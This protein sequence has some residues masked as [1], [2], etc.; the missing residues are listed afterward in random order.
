LIR[1][2]FSII[3]ALA[4]SL[5]CSA[6]ASAQTFANIPALSFAKA[7]GG[8]NPLPQ[9]LT[10]NSSG[11]TAFAYS[12]AAT[13][14]T[15]GA[16]LQVAPSGGACC[17]TP[18]TVTVSVAP[19]V[20]LA[21]GTYTGKIVLT[22]YSDASVTL[23]IPVTLT[24]SAATASFFDD[25]PGQVSFSLVPTGN[26][27]PSQFLQVRNGGTGALNWSLSSTTA[28]GGKWL[29]LSATSGAAPSLV[30]MAINPA[31]L[32]GAGKVAGAYIGQL[33]LAATGNSVT[34]PIS[35][36][37]G[38]DVF[39][40]VNAIN[41][42]KPFG[43]NDPLPQ[44]LTIASA[45][46]DS[47]IDVAAYNGA[48][49]NWLTVSPTGNACC[50]TPESVTVSVHPSVSLAAGTY[51]AEVVITEYSGHETAMTIPVTLTIGTPASQAFFDNMP[52]QVSFSLKTGGTAPPS[53]AVQVLN[54]GTGVLPWTLVSSTADGGKWLTVSAP[55]GTAPSTVSIGLN[56]ANLPNAGKV[57]GTFVGEVVFQAASGMV[58]IP[59]SV[60]VG[61]SVFEQVNAIAFTKPYAG[62]NPLPQTLTIASTGDDFTFNVAA[63][64][65]TGGNWLTVSPSGTAC[66]ATLGSVLVSV[67]A[68][69][70]LPAGTYTGQIVITKYSGNS[71]AMTVPVT[72]TVKSTPTYFDNLPGQMSFSF[73]TGGVVPPNQTVQIRNAGTGT[74]S[75]AGAASTSDGGKWL[76]VS[77]ASGTA[78]SAISVGINKAALP[79][80]GLIAGNFTGQ[81]VFQTTGDVVTIPVS[82][83][84]G[85]TVFEQVNAIN[86]TKPYAGANPLPQTL[87][88][89]STGSD[90]TVNVSSSTATGGNWLVV[91]PSGNA[92]CATPE[93][94]T[95]SVNP[96]STLAAGT[97][98]GQV[99]VTEYSGH[100]MSMTVPVTLTVA[101][102]TSAFFDSMPGQMTFSLTTN[103]K[104]PPSQPLQIRNGGSG[105]L[106]WTVSKSTSDGGNWLA[107]SA[108]SGV[109]PATASVSINPALLPSSGHVAGVFTGQLV[110]QTT[111][112]TVTVPVSVVV[113]DSV[114][115]QVN[116]LNF[117][118]P[119]A[120]ANPLPQ[121]ITVV[122]TGAD[123]T[124][125]AQAFTANGGNWLTVSPIGNA[126][127]ATSES[128][129]ITAAPASTLAAGTY[130]G[131]VIFTEYSG[132]GMSMTVPVTLTVAAA[133]TAFFDDVQ[134]QLSYSLV[135]KGAN[136]PSH[137]IQI[138]NGGT[139][140]L[141]WTLSSSTSDGGNWLT[142]SSLTGTAPSAVTISINN[143][144]LP[145]AGQVAGIFTG[146][147]LLQTAGDAVTIPVSVVVGDNVFQQLDTLA[148]SK[149]PNGANPA[150]QTISIT[151]TSAALTLD[152]LG[153]SGK[154]GSW[155]Q[156]TPSGTACCTTS[157]KLTVSVNPAANLAAGVYTAEIVATQYS[158]HG[159]AMT[160]PVYLEVGASTLTPTITTVKS[161][162]TPST[163][164]Q[165]VT[166][167]AT[168]TG[169]AGLSGTVTFNDGATA[170]GT[171]TLSGSTAVLT[172]AAL[173]TGSHSISA[174]Y[175][176][177]TLYSKS[178]SAAITQTVAAGAG[179]ATTTALTSSLNPSIAAGAVTFT[180]KV[181][182]STAGVA[183]N[184][185][186]KDGSTALA[187]V[188]LATGAASYSTTTLAAGAHSITAVYVGGSGFAAST[189]VALAQSVLKVTTTALSSSLNPA[190]FGQFVTLTA[191]VTGA[192]AGQNGYVTFFDGGVPIS[193]VPLNGTV[194]SVSL[195]SL[196]KGTHTITAVY[197]GSAIYAGSSSAAGSQTVK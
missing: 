81:L 195:S 119:Y 62:A 8:A 74:L 150:A 104:T 51:T 168:V 107:V 175:N 27:P 23:T 169:G 109:A 149:A 155:L 161:S 105:T 69:A 192:A 64:T 67:N 82:L 9:T 178:A 135:T 1:N 12:V 177:N 157:E 72:L 141:N 197:G 160:I 42:T 63:Y 84:V 22:K 193:S 49:G 48:G 188:P 190:T 171:A 182:S 129:T 91:S 70:S 10:V 124:I 158:G 114:F 76:T 37:V 127:C 194:A 143:A 44:T 55:S 128:F 75:W 14:T 21:A 25:L 83:F 123:F 31:A 132:H 164:G 24:I 134:G 179:A 147:V 89:A 100:G 68:P 78:P 94:L 174:A 96:A 26:T 121:T 117:T 181:S 36:T 90:F 17:T 50:A 142:A 2:L 166:F 11:A 33:L 126:C 18:S 19:A 97:Y 34:I 35:V 144:A 80:G 167:T 113:G 110:F 145:S 87:L 151:S 71:M 189:S 102:T 95:V 112:D 4:L 138:R 86:F 16:W 196:A 162:V 98:T 57:A 137:S 173:T 39:A 191:S 99:V 122:S 41:F 77:A 103:G 6:G 108:V 130:T 116:A 111:G 106:N 140:T 46:A 43:G 187:T 54:A 118:K 101:N 7:F 85:D 61:D 40:Q 15:G 186:F 28:D 153:Y 146:Q 185:T 38:P 183:G 139:G 20:S 52:G 156:V 133:T 3:A 58:T 180:A 93:S 170:L 29:T 159:M 92:C 131:E 79:G 66:C 172:T 53:Q 5:I 32:P 88:I 163:Y 60:T 120:G 184:V 73:K 125:N 176:G 13:S 154:G 152:V 59:V 148:F 30:S 45:G 56:P 115:E 47:T 65:A 165:A 136:P